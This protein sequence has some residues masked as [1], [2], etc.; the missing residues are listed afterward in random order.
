MARTMRCALAFLA[1]AASLVAGACAQPTRGADAP[2][3]TVRDQIT[4]EIGDARC[5]ESA[6]CRT[7]PLGSRACGGP[8]RYVAWSSQRSDGAKLAALA[9]RDAEERRRIN[10]DSG[11]ASTCELRPD[12]GAQCFASRCVLRS[13]ARPSTY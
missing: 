1:V 9:E 10:E 4:A 8:E 7:L 12:P 2:A 5:S 3:T 11:R 6:Q 13:T